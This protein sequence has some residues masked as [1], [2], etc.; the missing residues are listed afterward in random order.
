MKISAGLPGKLLELNFF[1][2]KKCKLLYSKARKEDKTQSRIKKT[3]PNISEIELF[4]KINKTDNPLAKL[5]KAKKRERKHKL[6]ASGMKERR[7]ILPN[8]TNI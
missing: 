1:L 8:P 3:K 7:D 5:F 4:E 2:R 6:S